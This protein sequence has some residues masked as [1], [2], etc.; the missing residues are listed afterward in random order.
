MKTK[1]LFRALT[2]AQTCLIA[3]VTIGEYATH[4]AKNMLIMTNNKCCKSVLWRKE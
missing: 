1:N 4:S 2:F 3:V